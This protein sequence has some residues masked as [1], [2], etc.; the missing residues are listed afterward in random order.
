MVEEYVKQKNITKKMK[1]IILL[2]FVVFCINNVIAQTL[3]SGSYSS[4]ELG[5]TYTVS[6]KQ[7]GNSITITEP[8]RVNLYKNNGGDTYYHTEQKYAGFYIRVAGDNKYYTGK[9]GKNKEY[10]FTFSGENTD[11]EQDQPSGIDNCPLYDKYLELSKKDHVNTQAWAFCG[12][13][14][15]AKCTYKDATGYLK[16]LIESLKL[17]IED[18]SKCPCTDAI[19][20]AEWNAVK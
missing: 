9:Q 1:K 13:A 8:N 15:L 4:S 11:S 10:L 17:I 5:Y 2:I 16:P 6:V 3:S 12:A 7:E 20:Q 18:A 19:T 14:A